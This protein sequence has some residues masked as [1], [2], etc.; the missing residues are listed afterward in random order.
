MQVLPADV[1]YYQGQDLERRR[2]RTRTLLLF[3]AVRE[4]FPQAQL[5][6]SYSLG[7]AYFYR[8]RNGRPLLPSDVDQLRDTMRRLA[9]EHRELRPETIDTELALRELRESQRVHTAAWVSDHT[10]AA[11]V[12]Y[13][14]GEQLLAFKGPLCDSTDEV[15][16]WDL[17]YY[18]PGVLLRFASHTQTQLGPYEE[19]PRLF[20]A[21][22]EGDRW[23]R[24]C[25]ASY[26]HEVNDLVRSGGIGELVQVAEALHARKIA[27][28]ADR[29]VATQPQPRVVLISGPSS[30]GK[31]S[32]SK[33]LQIQLRLLGKRP[34]TIG[35]DDFYLPRDRIPLRPNGDFDFEVLEALDVELFNDGLLRLIGGEQVCP[36][37][38]DF[39]THAR[40]DRPPIRLDHDGILLVEGIHGLNP[41]L[42][43]HLTEPS[44]FRVYVSAL[45]HLNLDELSRL[46]TTDLRL[47]RRLVR[48]RRARGYP[49]EETLARWP[50]VREGE[51]KHIF[52]HQERA[53][54]MFNSA[55]P[56]EI[57]ALK[58][59]VLEALAPVRQPDLRAE[60]ER[61][62]ALLDPVEPLAYDWL[63]QH[64]TPTS[65]LRE[66][67][68]GSALVP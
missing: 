40:A 30:S 26:V 15:E 46:S 6:L 13:R 5:H 7:S 61:M 60:C 10:R 47:M 39:Q 31:T 12:F 4:I 19:H 59:S 27:E 63:V 28:I 14:S 58:Q 42:T 67:V 8:V 36:P 57:N 45:T 1:P 50:V 33:R 62:T 41:A 49:A 34:L 37:R 23:G 55:L 22:F 66:F 56:Y 53:D 65:I 18:P 20:R 16:P 44:I 9:A 11:P 64:L 21:F 2:Q 68:G 29:I 32:F 24:V 38:L 17:A 54:V 25:G 52:P 3:A 48:D 43:P 51:S 35:L